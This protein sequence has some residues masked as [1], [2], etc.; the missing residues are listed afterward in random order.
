ME[1]QILSYQATPG[2]FC[3]KPIGMHRG[4]YHGIATF[5]G[6][7]TKI[8]CGK[9]TCEYCGPLKKKVLINRLIRG[10][11]ANDPA[12]GTQVPYAQKFITLTFGGSDIRRNFIVKFG[13]KAHIEAYTYMSHAFDKLIKSLK[14]HYGPFHYL[15]VMELHKD[16]WPHFHVLMVGRAIVDIDFLRYIEKLWSSYG[17][18]FVQ[19]MVIRHGIKAAVTYLCKYITKNTKPVG[20]N[21]RIFTASRGALQ[22]IQ[23]EK[24]DWIAQELF[25]GFVGDGPDGHTITIEKYIDSVNLSQDECEFQL[26]EFIIQTM[27]GF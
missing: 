15:R 9:W 22:R 18:G 3:R 4:V 23:K 24:K 13:D 14:K 2:R 25:A 5:I 6:T 27:K 19:G 11:I 17:L 8:T 1:S 12:L 20:Q 26:R 21:K 7:Q 16:G 10:A